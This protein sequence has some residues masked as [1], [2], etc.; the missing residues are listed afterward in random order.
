MLGS[1]QQPPDRPVLTSSARG[2]Q[3]RRPRRSH[4]T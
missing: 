2:A 4:P 1:T 3:P